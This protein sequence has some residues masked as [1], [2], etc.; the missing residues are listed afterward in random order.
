MN[1]ETNWAHLRLKRVQGERYRLTVD[2]K[3]YA[4]EY[5]VVLQENRINIDGYFD[6]VT[7]YRITAHDLRSDAIAAARTTGALY[8][9]EVELWP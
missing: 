9:L 2:F 7:L 3:V 1:S 4:N 8:D 6:W 5:C